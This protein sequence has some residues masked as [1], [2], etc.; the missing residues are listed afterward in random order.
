MKGVYSIYSLQLEN[1]RVLFRRYNIYIIYYIYI[2][3][4]FSQYQRSVN[5]IL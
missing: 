4:L 5:N 2:I 3:N 1:D